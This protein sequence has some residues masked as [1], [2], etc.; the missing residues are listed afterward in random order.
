MPKVLLYITSKTTWIFLFFGTD[1][2]ENRAHVHIGKKSMEEYCKVWLEPEISI[3]KTG[4]LTTSELNEILKITKE[5][6]SLLIKQWKRF[7]DG[8]T[9]KMINIKK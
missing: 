2:N 1:I 9:I 6:H 5:Y 4:E 8:K 7:S 3:A